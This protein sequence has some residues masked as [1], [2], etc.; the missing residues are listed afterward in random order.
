MLIGKQL[1]M[2]QRSKLPPISESC[3][4]RR[5]ALLPVTQPNCQKLNMQM[6]IKHKFVPWSSQQ[7]LPT[8]HIPGYGV[9]NL[10]VHV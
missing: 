4:Q 5:V 9:E 1:L 8:N 7:F 6:C 2:Y 3:D 10:L